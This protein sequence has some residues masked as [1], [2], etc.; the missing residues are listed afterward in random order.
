MTTSEH[1]GY[2]CV[3]WLLFANNTQWKQISTQEEG[4]LQLDFRT[5]TDESQVDLDFNGLSVYA[6]CQDKFSSLLSLVE[7]GI[8]F[9]D[10]KEKPQP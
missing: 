4:T 8:A 2:H 1:V 5:V 3:E 9:L 10:W 7:T 6:F